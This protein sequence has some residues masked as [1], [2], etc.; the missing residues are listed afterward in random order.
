MSSSGHL[1]VTWHPLRPPL[2]A[3]L[4][5]L[6]LRSALAVPSCAGDLCK[7]F[8]LSHACMRR[9]RIN[10]VLAAIYNAIFIPLAAGVVYPVT[11]WQMS[12]MLAGLS[13]VGSSIIVV[14][15]SLFLYLYRPP[16]FSADAKA[17]ELSTIA[18][19]EPEKD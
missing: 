18:S 3:C 13:M 16:L 12:P 5:S 11:H 17:A 1:A 8:D 9:I 2:V 14:V 10:F 19:L 7:I 15:S 6:T 4:L